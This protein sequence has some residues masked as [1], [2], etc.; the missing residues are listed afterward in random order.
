M[1]RRTRQ[2]GTLVLTAEAIAYLIWKI[3]LGTTLDVL[4]QTN[5]AWFALAVAI[6]IG[7]IPALALRWGWL[8][9]AHGIHERV[10]WLTRAL[11]GCRCRRS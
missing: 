4:A 3:E 11:Q 1:T 10:P 5:L 9:G 7:T 8:L 6:M 2:V